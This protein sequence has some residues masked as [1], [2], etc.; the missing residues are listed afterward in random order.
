MTLSVTFSSLFLLWSIFLDVCVCLFK[1]RQY[2]DHM[3]QD[4]GREAWKWKLPAGVEPSPWDY[5]LSTIEVTRCQKCLTNDQSREEKQHQGKCNQRWI[6]SKL[7]FYTSLHFSYSLSR[8][9]KPISQRF[10]TMYPSSIQTHTV[11][12]FHKRWNAISSK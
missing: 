6:E 8:L 2:K 11:H 3:K 7:H 12:H 10:R 5:S 4:K 9:F 1:S